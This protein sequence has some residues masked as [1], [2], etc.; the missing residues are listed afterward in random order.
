MTTSL[1]STLEKRIRSV[2]DNTAQE[3][4]D[5]I[6]NNKSIVESDDEGLMESKEEKNAEMRV[7]KF[8]G[9]IKSKVT[10]REFLDMLMVDYNMG[11]QEIIVAKDKDLVKIYKS[12]F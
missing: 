1:Y 7:S 11:A 8:L 3:G 9:S 12:E 10:P 2:M 5:K 4:F 6:T